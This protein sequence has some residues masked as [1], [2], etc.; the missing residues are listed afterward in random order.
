LAAHRGTA[1]LPGLAILAPPQR[2]GDVAAE[3]IADWRIS[4]AMMHDA[5][6]AILMREQE[7]HESIRETLISAGSRLSK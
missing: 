2:H 1:H 3:V 6:T 5:H 7:L 4:L